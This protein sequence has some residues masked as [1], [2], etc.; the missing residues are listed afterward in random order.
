MKFKTKMVLATSFSIAVGLVLYLL[1][2]WNEQQ[3]GTVVQKNHLVHQILRDL[4]SLT[5][6]SQD[7][8]LYQEQRALSQWQTKYESLSQ[9]I[10]SFEPFDNKEQSVYAKLQKDHQSL[11][12]IFS[13]LRTFREAGARGITARQQEAETLLTARLL[14]KLQAIASHAEKIVGQSELEIINANRQ[15]TWIVITLITATLLLVFMNSFLLNRNII[16]P[17]Q[18]LKKG[19]QKIRAGYLDY[20]VEESANNEAGALSIAFNQMT[21]ELKSN[22][23]DLLRLNRDLEQHRKNLEMLVEERTMELEKSLYQLKKTTQLLVH[24]EKMS[25]TGIMAAGIAHEL[26]N[27]IMGI[28]NYVQYCLKHTDENDRRHG[29]LQSAEQEILRCATILKNLLTFARMGQEGQESYLVENCV[30]LLERALQLLDYRIKHNQVSIL[31]EYEENTFLVR[32]KANP[33]Q[34]VFLNLLGNALDALEPCHVQEI[35]LQINNQSPFV[36]VGIHDS[37]PGMEREQLSKIF[38]PFYTTKA[39]GKGTGLGLA[40][41]QSIIEEHQGRLSCESTLG[42]GTL[43]EVLLPM[44]SG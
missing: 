23:S 24:A 14:V 28:L 1:L 32:V 12:I 25:A 33:I 3:I 9:L 39:P 16:M 41:C 21:R 35:H 31:R 27:P 4:L 2:V 20:Q 17:I 37:G 38:D 18:E 11:Q 22:Q 6:V 30:E 5:I 43:F 26:N 13:K 8:L 15:T 7:Y 40:I 44:D 42:Q 29:I 36:R 34:Q 19:M 10:Q